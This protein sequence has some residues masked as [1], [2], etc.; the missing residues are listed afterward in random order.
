MSLPT[1]GEIFDTVMGPFQEEADRQMQECM[2]QDDDGDGVPNS[3]SY[4]IENRNIT[5][6]ITG[7]I[8][9]AATGVIDKAGEEIRRILDGELEIPCAD[10]P[11]A[12]ADK[13]QEIL[14]SIF[15]GVWDSA[16]P[17]MP[18]IPDWVRAIIIAG[19]YGDDVIRGIE[20]STNT[21]IDGDGTIGL[22]P[23]EF[24]CWD[25]SIVDDPSQCPPEQ[26]D[27]T[28]IGK[29]N[30]ADGASSEAD[31][32]DPCPDNPEVSSESPDCQ[33][34][35]D[36]GTTQEQCA[37][38]GRTHIPGDANTQTPSDCGGCSDSE[39]TV[40]QDEGN[41]MSPCVAP[42]N[43]DPT[44]GDPCNTGAPLNAEGTIGPAPDYDCV[45]IEGATC[46]DSDG[47][48]GNIVNG[49]CDTGTGQPDDGTDDERCA[50]PTPPQT[51]AE[52]QYCFDQGYAPCEP[53]DVQYGDGRWYKNGDCTPEDS[54]E[55]CNNVDCNSPRPDS[56]TY[57]N[58]EAQISWDKCCSETHCT[59]GNPIQD[60]FDCDGNPTGPGD[61]GC[62]NG[63]TPESECNQCPGNKTIPAWHVDGDCRNPVT[64]AG[65]SC[66]PNGEIYADNGDCVVP[67]N[68]EDPLDCSEI[69]DANYQECGKEKCEDGSF[70]D[71]G[72]CPTGPQECAKPDGTLTGATLESNC[73]Q[74][75]DG[76]TFDF[77][78]ICQADDG[79]LNCDDYNRTTNDDGTCGPCKDGYEVATGLPDEPCVPIFGGCPAGYE[80][81][82]ESNECIPVTCPDGQAFCDDTGQC[83]DI[84]TCP[85]DPPTTQATNTF[86]FGGSAGGGMMTGRP[87]GYMGDP[88]LLSRTEFPI[89]DFL[90]G[91]FSN[92][93][94]K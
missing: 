66:G 30:P 41:S 20:T 44:E 39:N 40:P 89:T 50:G 78:G 3:A 42:E 51:P 25:G 33:P 67:D 54:G 9:D 81:D 59:N 7:T 6:I 55:E 46:T 47:N 71:V 86:G 92:L 45:P 29:F 57:D 60:G 10:D 23:E 83:E 35:E 22:T 72:Q 18:G 53:G 34:W 76:Y 79:T 37:S 91:L 1:I 38:L 77:N 94:G 2:G 82:S 24:E 43:P 88:Q 19:E 28:T 63:A 16:D 69:T 26:F 56:S 85:S 61:D 58:Q 70:A 49:V 32:V 52:K 14:G 21:D 27:C 31:C 17:T 90:A 80:L 73:E 11:Q 15:E 87:T 65:E 36:A 13:V 62:P 74:C 75:P 4:C 48:S 8:S 64:Y 12:C 93:R 84:G 5:D 68:P